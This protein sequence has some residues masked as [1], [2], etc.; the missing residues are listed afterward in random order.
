M[1]LCCEDFLENYK[2]FFSTLTTPPEIF[3]RACL[4]PIFGFKIIKLINL[5]CAL[6]IIAILLSYALLVSKVKPNAIGY[7]I[8]YAFSVI[9]FSCL[10]MLAFANSSKHFFKHYY[11][12]GYLLT[13]LLNNLTMLFIIEYNIFSCYNC[14]L[15]FICFGGLFITS[16]LLL[17]IFLIYLIL[18]TISCAAFFPLYLCR[19]IRN[20]DVENNVETSTSNLSSSSES[21]VEI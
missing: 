4:K 16:V 2:E 9:S 15:F 10:I 20:T 19:K 18:G 14:L 11:I 5:T 1:S 21:L 7:C 8:V 17:I 3:G 12:N 13:V 6:Q